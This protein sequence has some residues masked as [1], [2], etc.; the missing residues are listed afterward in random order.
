MMSWIASEAI[1]ALIGIL[2]GLGTMS[3]YYRF[4]NGRWF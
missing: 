4:R 2:S 3:V 1:G